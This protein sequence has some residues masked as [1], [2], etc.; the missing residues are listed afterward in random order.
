MTK[1]LVTGAH[2]LLGSAIVPHLQSR[3]FDVISHARKAGGDIEGDLTDSNQVSTMVRTIEPDIII[4]L[5]AFTNVDM[6]ELHPQLAYLSNVKIIENLV[7]S[8]RPAL[9]RCHLLQLSTDQVYDGIG[10]HKED[11]V[12]LCNYYAFSKY[13]GELAAEKASATV[14]RTNFFGPSR[15][16]VRKSLSDWLVES[17]QQ[18]KPITV[19][20]DVHFSP[21]S[22]QTLITMI[23][24]ILVEPQQ[25]VFNLGS[26]LGMSK[27]D[28]AFSLARA[29]Q[30]PTS[31]MSRGSSEKLKL[32]ASRPKDMRIDS[33]YF[34]RAFGVKLP[35]L[36][37][38]IELMKVAYAF[39][40]R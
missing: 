20:D 27:A 7:R 17:L 4:N 33:S 34:E 3:G 5:A 26:R 6:C 28:F 13:A 25:G 2:G 16:P 36:E 38:E 10:P 21:L 19:F 9:N 32:P 11:N 40:A 1:I 31:R 22:I 12:T 35:T 18:E 8:I 29:L 39:K 37:E 23:D 15:C 30:M 14:L 24:L